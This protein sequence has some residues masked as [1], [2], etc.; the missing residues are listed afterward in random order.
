M[1]DETMWAADRVVA[2]TPGSTIAI[3]ETVNEFA[4]KGN[5]LTLLKGNQFDGRTKTDPHKHIHEFLGIYDMFWELNV[6]IL[7][8]VK[9]KNTSKKITINRSD[10]AG[11]DKAKVKCFN[12]YKM[13]NFA[14]E[15]RVPRNQKNKTKNQETT[16]RTVNV[17]D[18]SSKAMVATD[19]AGFDWSYMADDEAPTNMAF[20]AFLDSEI[21][22]DNTYSKTSC[23]ACGRF[24]HLQARCKYHQRERMEIYPTSLTSSSLMEGILHFGEELKVIRLL[25]KMC[26]KKNSVLFTDT[27]CFVL[28][29]N[30][31][32]ADESHVLLKVSRKNNMYNVDMKNIIPRNN[33]TCLVAKATN[34]ES[35]LWHRRLSHINFKNI[36][37]LVKENLVR[38]LPS[39]RFK[40]DQTC[41]ACLKGKQ[42]KV[43]FK[44][45]I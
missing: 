39:K 11:Y 44:S 42:H 21:Y 41:V 6:Y 3:P 25:E 38:D 5:H 28:S 43:S 1:D 26:D 18:T 32:L 24:N 19:G 15:C 8:T 16:K 13:G 4:I 17:E 27:E 9:T 34:D 10:T 31:K 33:L 7:S 40:N 30:I 12:C 45:K 29:P 37:K 35:M 22:P 20:M 23:Y 36:N 14:R 2:L